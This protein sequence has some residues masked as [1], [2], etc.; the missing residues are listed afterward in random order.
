MESDSSRF[1]AK[2]SKLNISIDYK[3]ISIGLVA[4]IILMAIL[5][6]PWSKSIAS[7]RT[8]E[9]SGSATVTA[10]PDKYVFYPSYQFKNTD[11][12]AALTAM[13]K[14]NDEVV[15][16]LKALGVLDKDIKTSADGNDYLVFYAQES[17]ATTY[18]L[19]LTI[20]TLDKDLAQKVEDYLL[21]TEP[22][23]SVTP[24]A[25]F[26]DQ[27]RKSL[28]S[29]A[30]DKATKEARQKAD[31]SATNLGFKVGGVKSVSDSAGFGGIIRPMAASADRATGSAVSAV[32]TTTID[33][34]PGQ[35]D[36]SYTVTVVYYIR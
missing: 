7:D 26:S 32:E 16:K 22:L 27:K 5:W 12:T 31:Q 13:T 14:K 25:D 34:Q 29:D 21:T 11:K 10:T 8:I 6:K 15:K 24:Q 35:N 3:V 23:A 17:K 33:I 19:Q 36:L 28:E 30:R 1:S 9:V 20:N 2:S 18:S 4:I